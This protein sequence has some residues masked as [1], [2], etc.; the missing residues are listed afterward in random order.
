MC[1]FFLYHLRPFRSASAISS[2]KNTLFGLTFLL[3]QDHGHCSALLF[4][5]AALHSF[6][7]RMLCG[8]RVRVFSE[9]T[10]GGALVRQTYS[11]DRWLTFHWTLSI[12][13][14]SGVPVYA[15]N[16]KMAKVCVLQINSVRAYTLLLL[17]ESANRARNR[18]FLSSFGTMFVR[19]S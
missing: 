14:L 5:R 3:Q 11:R 2:S 18:A 13:R 10:N 6:A 17:L 4:D 19:K 7:T 8:V 16:G 1:T 9:L 12:N 15:P